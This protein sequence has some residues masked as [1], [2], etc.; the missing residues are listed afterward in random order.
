ME[1]SG[2]QTLVEFCFG[3]PFASLTQFEEKSS[4]LVTT[5]QTAANPIR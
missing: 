4:E 1:G 5:L 2:L 3:A